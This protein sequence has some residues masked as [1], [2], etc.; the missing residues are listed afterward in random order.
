MRKLFILLLI[1]VPIYS[2]SQSKK[3]LRKERREERD[4]AFQDKQREENRTNEEIQNK[5]ELISKLSGVEYAII[6]L[7]S[8]QEK[9]LLSNPAAKNDLYTYTAFINFLKKRFHFK[10]VALTHQQRDEIYKMAN[11]ICSIVFAD[12]STGEFHSQFGAVGVVKGTK[13]T[14]TFCDSSTYTIN[15]LDIGVNGLTVWSN[16]IKRALNGIDLPEIDYNKNNE[17]AL[18]TLPY[19]VSEDS[20]KLLCNEKDRKYEGIFQSLGNEQS[21]TGLKLGIIKIKDSIDLIYLG[22]D[23][24]AIDWKAGELKG[25]LESTKSDKIFFARLFNIL[26]K[27]IPENGTLIFESD[28]NSFTLQFLNTNLKFVRIY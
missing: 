10:V 12:I 24:L 17:L 28:F 16:R 13:I 19:I 1:F 23:N 11:G 26:K 7:S 14:F 25:T 22:G 27:P 21:A 9:I 5:A 15:M 3:D 20:L 2:N 8:D 18:P 6:P 4:Q